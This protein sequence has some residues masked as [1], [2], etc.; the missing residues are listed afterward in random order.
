[1]D[2]QRL[3]GSERDKLGIVVS[4]RS[5]EKPY[6][7]GSKRRFL[8]LEWPKKGRNSP[9]LFTDSLLGKKYILLIQWKLQATRGV[10]KRFP[11]GDGAGVYRILGE[12]TAKVTKNQ[13]LWD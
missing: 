10:E 7:F 1:M 8:P 4:P 12:E 9:F 11:Q 3:P 13:G 6:T 5:C 2:K